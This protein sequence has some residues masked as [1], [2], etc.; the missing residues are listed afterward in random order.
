MRLVRPLL[1][2]RERQ[3]KMATAKR[4]EIEITLQSLELLV[5]GVSS[6]PAESNHTLTVE[7]LWPRTGTQSK[8]YSRLIKLRAGKCVFTDADWYDSILLKDAVFGRFALK[9]T[10]SQVLSDTAVAKLLQSMA[11]VAASSVADAMAASVDKP[12]GQT[13]AA[14]IDYIASVFAGEAVQ[15][16]AE[17]I[18]TLEPEFISAG[19]GVLT[20]PL[21]CPAKITKAVVSVGKIRKPRKQVIGK[22]DPNGTAALSIKLI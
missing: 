6:I 7:L 14:P 2:C 21:S 22:G 16:V 11:K 20:L 12:L 15:P 8:A 10:V 19:G 5:T 9:V 4:E 18:I 17:G 3:F 1:Q 13:L